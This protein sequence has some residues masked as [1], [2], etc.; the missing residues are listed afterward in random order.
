MLLSSLDGGSGLGTLGTIDITDKDGGSD[1]VDLSAA[2]TLQDVVDAINASSADVTASINA[3]KTGIEIEDTSGGTGLLTIANGDATNT[4]A[5]LQI[6]VSGLVDSVDSG[7]LH[8]QVVSKN[9]KLED[10]NGGQGI[11]RG[12][13]KLIDTAG[14]EAIIDFSDDRIETLGDV[15][16]AL[17]ANVANVE[18]TINETGDGITIRDLA[19]GSGSLQVLEGIGSTAAQ[20]LGIFKASEPEW[21]EGETVRVINGSFAQEIQVTSED[22]LETIVERL[23]VSSSKV[24][25][26]V[27]NDGSDRPYRLAINSQVTGEAGNLVFDVSGLDFTLSDSVKGQDALIALGPPEHAASSLLLSSSSN[28]FTSAVPGVS[29]NV[30]M[31]TGS[32]V[33]IQVSQGNTSLVASAQTFVE[34]Y[35]KFW[36]LITGYTAY[37]PDTDTRNILTGDPTAQQV[38]SSV[39][40]LMSGQT[41]APLGGI[42]SLRELGFDLSSTGK[43]SLDENTLKAAFAANPQK[44][45]NFFKQTDANTDEETGFSVEIGALI[46]R[47]TSTEGSLLTNRYLALGEIIDNNEERVDYL[48]ERLEVEEL[49]LYKEFYRME[50]AIAKIQN[51]AQYL[52][53]LGPILIN[54][55]R[56]D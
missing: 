10:L 49:R 37:D 20:D 8:L 5:A 41:Y 44:V 16:T 26:A 15:L 31:A 6:S 14:E 9:T 18:A 33:T 23:N 38:L 13:I 22:T 7:D 42:R 35:N 46:E 36:S 40:R 27:L 28:T 11:D 56:D 51:S 32:A 52:E 29:M 24:N 48:T 45:K 12:I 47:L 21:I 50:I 39:S 54:S 2:E 4:A 17:S 30:A 55:S 53:G 25:A 34:N 1:S 19:G 3:S 43:L